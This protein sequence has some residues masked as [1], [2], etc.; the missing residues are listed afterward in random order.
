MQA[1][2]MGFAK[3]IISLKQRDWAKQQPGWTAHEIA[4]HHYPMATTPDATADLLM[5]IAK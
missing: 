1:S 4:S 3:A 5:Q 2:S